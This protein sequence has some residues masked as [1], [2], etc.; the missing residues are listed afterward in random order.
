MS[1]REV[2]NEWLLVTGG[3]PHYLLEVPVVHPC[4]FHNW[5][6]CRDI[7][8][9]IGT[10]AVSTPCTSSPRSFFVD[11]QM[12]HCAHQTVQDRRHTRCYIAALDERT[13]CRACV[14]QELCWTPAERGQ[15]PC[16]S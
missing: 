4:R 15:L 14:Y 11:A 2:P 3:G 7:D 1:L 8:R 5:A 6:D 16:E 13:C 12:Y 9:Q 10:A